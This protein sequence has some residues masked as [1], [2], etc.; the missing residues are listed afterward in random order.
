MIFKELK[1]FLDTCTLEQLDSKVV[2]FKNDE[3]QGNELDSWEVSDED[4]YWMDGDCYGDRKTTEEQILEM[5]QSEQP[6]EPYTL[7]DF[8]CV[9]KGTITLHYSDQPL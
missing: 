4:F 1:E 6:D 2:V 7:D 8:F 5:N 9:P 3:E